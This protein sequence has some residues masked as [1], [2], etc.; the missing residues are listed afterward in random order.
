MIFSARHL[1]VLIV[2]VTFPCLAAEPERV[3]PETALSTSP[4]VGPDSGL[5][6]EIDGYRRLAGEA[7]ARGNLEL[8]EIFYQHL[9][10]VEA[11][12]EM[13]EPALLE[14]AEL[15]QKQNATAKAI[16]VLEAIREM[17]PDDPKMPEWL[18]RLGDLYRDSGAYQTAIA[19]YYSV[20]NSTLK[21]SHPQ[22]EQSKGWAEQAQFRIAETHFQ[23]GDYAQA[24]KFFTL[25]GKLDLKRDDKA[26]ALFRSTYCLYLLD[27]KVSAEAS[28]RRFL[29]DYGDTKFAPECR[30]VLART[31]Q[32]LNRSQEAMDEV[33]NLLRTEK[34][35]EKQDPV[36]WTYWQEKAGNQVANDFYLHGD[37]GRAINVYQALA[38]LNNSP[39][40]LWPVIY[41]MGLCFERLE[42]PERAEQAYVFIADESKK[43]KA[44]ASDALTQ[45][46]KMAG[47]RSQHL[48]WKGQTEERLESL[49]GGP[50]APT[51]TK[52]SS[53][54]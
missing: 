12:A 2:V 9:L 45:I 37:F 42:L 5:Q 49:L 48:G 40:W 7:I 46:V 21:S 19:R 36:I 30:Y 50:V 41:Q 26:L 15:Y 25:L 51:E 54:P 8:A 1:I 6:T 27:D 31:L 23:Q 4:R 14:M 24:N 29:Q 18:L 10:S 20:I 33:L 28:A 3:L 38:K 17:A 16:T 13:K 47:W 35:S 44:P 34:K 52:L 53:T 32:S 43:G 11:P 22:F 39:D